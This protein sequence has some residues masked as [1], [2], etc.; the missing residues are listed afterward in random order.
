MKKIIFTLLALVASMAMPALA[1]D[2]TDTLYVVKGGKLVGTYEVGKDVDYISFT[3]PVTPPD[4]GGNYVQYG[5][6]REAMKSAFVMKQ[7]GLLYVILSPVEGLTTYE[8]ITAAGNYLFVAIPED[9]A[10]EDIKFTDYSDSDDYYQAVYM[11][12][13]YEVLAGTTN[14]EISDCDYSELTVKVGLTDDEVSVSVHGDPLAEG[15][16]A[17]DASYTGSYA[18]PAEASA[19]T[20][21][22]DGETKELRAAFYKVNEDDA[23]VDL[24]FTSGN[25]DDAKKL[26]DCYQYA[27]VQVPYSALAGGEIDITGGGQ[28]Q[29]DLYDNIAEQ[30]YH[31][32]TDNV[33]TATGTISVTMMAENSY[34]FSVDIQDLTLNGTSHTFQAY[35]EGEC[36][37]YDTSTPNAYR[38]QGQ[39]DVE[40]KSAVVTHSGDIYTVYLSKKDGVTTVEGMSDADIV[41]EVPDVF[42]TDERKGFS[43]TEDNAKISVTYDGVKYNQASTKGSDANALGGGMKTKLENG[44]LAIEFYV[45]N[46]Y[47]YDDANLTGYYEGPVTVIE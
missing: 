34:A 29:F 47:Q 37:P 21:T 32:S 24:Y 7:D 18:S 46:I 39:D 45:M 15:G 40:L 31:L 43:G 5:D 1:Q 11:S 33:G 12:A 38:L 22:F 16:S 2:K 10:G 4:A 8:E 14:Y 27:H 6:T 26:E 19:N 35:Y 9:K 20:F 23:T 30:E 25:I 3:K 13:D 36:M 41:V 17:F 28:F 44:R 42:M